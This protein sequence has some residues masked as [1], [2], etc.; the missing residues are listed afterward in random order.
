MVLVR[1]CL[2]R[3]ISRGKGIIIVIVFSVSIRIV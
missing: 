1:K 2:N 3:V